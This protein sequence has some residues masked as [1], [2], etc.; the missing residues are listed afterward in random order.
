MKIFSLAVLF[1]LSSVGYSKSLTCRSEYL[2][3]TLT[4]PKETAAKWA[5]LSE[6]YSGSREIKN[7]EAQFYVNKDKKNWAPEKGLFYYSVK[8]IDQ[9]ITTQ[10][11]H[12]D[13]NNMVAAATAKTDKLR[14]VFIVD[15]NGR[16]PFGFYFQHLN[17]QAKREESVF[18]FAVNCEI[19][20]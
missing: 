12:E 19:E 18:G 8:F 6:D 17:K 3:K 5:A 20:N 7:E 2:M 13:E 10:I 1:V 15:G 14:T 9:T 4:A 16:Q 11:F